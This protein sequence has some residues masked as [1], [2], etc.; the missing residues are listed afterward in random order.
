MKKNQRCPS[1]FAISLA[2]MPPT[3]SCTRGPAPMAITNMISPGRGL[4]GTRISTASKWL[5]T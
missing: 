3:R 1:N 4:S 5:R 2:R